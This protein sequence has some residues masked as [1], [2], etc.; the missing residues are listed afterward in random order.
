MLST[1]SEA[2]VSSTVLEKARELE[3]SGKVEEALMCARNAVRDDPQDKEAVQLARKLAESLS[4]Q[5]DRTAFTESPQGLVSELQAIL[6]ALEDRSKDLKEVLDRLLAMSTDAGL[7]RSLHKDAKVLSVIFNFL[8]GDQEKLKALKKEEICRIL[9]LLYS[10]SQCKDIDWKSQWH[11]EEG[12]ISALL[13]NFQDDNEQCRY[14]WLSL[15]NFI[16]HEV[17]MKVE[18]VLDAFFAAISSSISWQRQLASTSL[19]TIANSAV[20]L[21]HDNLKSIF[22]ELLE[23]ILVNKTICQEQDFNNAALLLAHIMEPTDVDKLSDKAQDMSTLA[24]WIRGLFTRLYDK[25]NTKE[26]AIWLLSTSC[27]VSAQSSNVLFA[28]E[29]FLTSLLDCLEYEPVTIQVAMMDLLSNACSSKNTLIL[30]AEQCSAYLLQTVQKESPSLRNAAAVILSKLSASHNISTTSKDRSALCKVLLSM[31]NLSSDFGCS[32]K[33]AIEGLAFISTDGDMKQLII[34]DTGALDNLLKCESDETADLYGI[35][36]IL[37][38]LTSFKRLLTD[39][40]E[41]VKKLKEFAK[42]STTQRESPFDEEVHVKK[43]VATLLKC[44]AVKCLNRLAQS[45]SANVLLSVAATYLSCASDTDLRGL[46]VQQGAVKSLLRITQLKEKNPNGTEDM[47]TGL[48]QSE[49]PAPMVASHAIA[50]IAVSLDPGIAF[51]NVAISLVRPFMDL[52]K[53]NSPLAQFE[54]LL[55]ITNL[56]SMGE[57]ALLERIYQLG[58]TKVFEELQFSENDRIQCAATEALCNMVVHPQVFEQYSKSKTGSTRVRLNLALCDAESFT[59][60]RAASGLLAMISGESEEFCEQLIAE[61]NFMSVISNLLKPEEDSEIHLRALFL[62]KSMVL[63]SKIKERVCQRELVNA[64]QSIA[65]ITNHST[66]KS[67][68]LELAQIM[69]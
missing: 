58:G 65:R 28:Q 30:I 42:Q 43:R 38:N 18:L 16:I 8:F 64:V 29:G 45:N 7:C 23:K 21:T 34:Q 61:E 48:G 44:G 62:I 52:C 60:R 53:S 24:A 63:S 14:A 3:K 6:N 37:Q 69:K 15:N 68:A 56:A 17:Q 35:S 46:M 67:C 50:R 26:C 32:R 39:E 33:A 27:K 66:V 31:L 49:F 47:P 11:L 4:I 36:I 20:K 10:I 51:K 57:P 40:E 41:Q 22:Q 25:D 12:Y 9:R 59:T 54:A 55:A 13:S 2:A 1:Q 19:L 5:Q